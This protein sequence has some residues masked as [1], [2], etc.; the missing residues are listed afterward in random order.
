M[1]PGYKKSARNKCKSQFAG[2]KRP[3]VT[4]RFILFTTSIVMERSARQSGSPIKGLT[5]TTIV[6]A[7][8]YIAMEKALAATG[9][10]VAAAVATG[11]ELVIGGPIVTATAGIVAVIGKSAAVVVATVVAVRLLGL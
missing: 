10:L 3:L 11:E 9:A 2:S 7:G 6:I 8:E 1:G 4:V 5:T